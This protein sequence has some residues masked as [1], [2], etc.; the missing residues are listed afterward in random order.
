MKAVTEK[1]LYPVFLRYGL[2]EVI[3]RTGYSAIYV[4]SIVDGYQEPRPRFMRAV[5]AAF[6]AE[7]ETPRSLFGEKGDGL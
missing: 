5:A 7:G 1:A 3:S 2:D 4:A 6:S